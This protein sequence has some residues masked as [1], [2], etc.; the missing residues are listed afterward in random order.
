MNSTAIK[1][2]FRGK[3][4][5]ILILDEGINN[6]FRFSHLR[7]TNVENLLATSPSHALKERLRAN[8]VLYL[9]EQ[10]ELSKINFICH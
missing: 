7:K 5:P 3:I 6:S 10:L 9:F 2:H 1:F 8:F 4:A